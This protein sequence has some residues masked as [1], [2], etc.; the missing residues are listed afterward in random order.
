MLTVQQVLDR[1]EMLASDLEIDAEN[2]GQDWNDS[3]GQTK[4]E[5]MRMSAKM[6]RETIDSLRQLKTDNK[7]K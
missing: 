4:N 6:I 3:V 5:T 1:F 2:Y 7:S